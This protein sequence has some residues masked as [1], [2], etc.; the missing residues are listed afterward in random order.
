MK[1]SKE[2]I[3][4]LKN[5]S[6]INQSIAVTKGSKLSTISNIKNIFASTTVAE[7]FPQDF[8]IYD[9]NEFLGVLSLFNEPELTFNTEFVLIKEGSQTQKYYFTDSSVITTAPNGVSL[10]KIEVKA[11]LE[12]ES[13]GKVLRAASTINVNDISFIGAD[14]KIIIQAWSKSNPTS[15][16]FKVEVGKTTN[17][18]NFNM[19][20]DDFKM[21]A[22]DYTVELSAKGV[23]KFISKDSDLTYFVSLQSDS[24]YNAG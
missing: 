18:F 20:T 12:K 5:F 24:F 22:S 8:A 16:T 17:D 11:E 6:T 13:L 14:K 2:T 10:P 21:M 1:I 3:A 9:L 4:I 23:A 15:N 19:I 7:T